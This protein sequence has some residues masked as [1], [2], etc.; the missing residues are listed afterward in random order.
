M[1]ECKTTPKSTLKQSVKVNKAVLAVQVFLSD[2][3][4]D[5]FG[6]VHELIL[7]NSWCQYQLIFPY[8]QVL[9]KRLGL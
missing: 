4:D 8:F 9:I 2:G 6:S 3:D 7:S 1:A 5:Y